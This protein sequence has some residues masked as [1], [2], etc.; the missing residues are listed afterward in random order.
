MNLKQIRKELKTFMY[1]SVYD[2][3]HKRIVLKKHIKYNSNIDRLFFPD[4][5]NNSTT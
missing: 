5:K 3:R 2:K 4:K 1:S